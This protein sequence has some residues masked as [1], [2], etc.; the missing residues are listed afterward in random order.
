MLKIWNIVPFLAWQKKCKRRFTTSVQSKTRSGLNVGYLDPDRTPVGGCS[1]PGLG[2]WEVMGLTGDSSSINSRRCVLVKAL[3][4]QGKELQEELSRLCAVRE[5]EHEIDRGFTR[6]LA[7][8]RP[9]PCDAGKERQ[10]K[11][12]LEWVVGRLTRWEKLEA[13]DLWQQKRGSFFTLRS[14]FTE[15]I[16]MSCVGEQASLREASEWAG[17]AQS[18]SIKRKWWMMVVRG[19]LLQGWNHPSSDQTC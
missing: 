6:N 18:T 2:Q 9:E 19:P 3:S 8:G 4:H 10:V 15:L 17:P 11:A 16:V 1:Q 12:T 14:E 5:D 7:E 13:C